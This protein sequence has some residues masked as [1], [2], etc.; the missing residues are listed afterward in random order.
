M[1]GVKGQVQRRGVERREAILAAAIEVFAVRGARG[2]ALA[3]IGE[4]AGTTRAGVLHHFGSKEGLLLAAIKERDR[5][6]GEDFVA[7]GQEGGVALLRG[8]MRYAQQAED[9]PGLSALHITL[10]VEN[11]Y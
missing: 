1:A 9:E 10:L 2:G 5:R 4:R 7:L 3:E 11:L 8:L 6:A